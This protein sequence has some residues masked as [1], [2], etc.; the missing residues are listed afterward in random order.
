MK[1]SLYGKIVGDAHIDESHPSWYI[2]D[3]TLLNLCFTFYNVLIGMFVF[4]MDKDKQKAQGLGYLITR[5]VSTMYIIGIIMY[6]EGLDFWF[7]CVDED[8]CL[9]QSFTSYLNCCTS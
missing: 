9:Q 7:C 3:C 5:H 6:T 8:Y 1:I 2:Y 4:C